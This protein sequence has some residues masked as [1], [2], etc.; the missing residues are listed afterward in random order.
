[1]PELRMDDRTLERTLGD[2]G[3][4]LAYAPPT[5]LRRAV[6]ARIATA[7]APAAR[8]WD[9]IASPRL[10]L[11]PAAIALAV[12][13]LA[14]A[15]ASPGVR[16]AAGEIL[17]IGGIDIFR[18][19]ATA[20]PSRPAGTV[21]PTTRPTV[22]PAPTFGM[23]VTLEQARAQAGYPI[24][25]PADPL[26][27]APDEVYLRV[28]GTNTQVTLLYRV[29]AGIPVSPQ[30]GVS[31]LIVYLPGMLETGFIG[32]GIGP[33]SRVDLLTVNGGPGAWISGAPHQIF[34]RSGSNVETEELRLAGNTLVWQEGPMTIR[35]E[36]AVDQA[37][38]LRIAG[39]MR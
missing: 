20:S 6:L 30:A 35:I 32:K 22:S 39:T 29:R 33:D 37:T 19:P 3:A 36:A 11:R 9:H 34:Y 28:R 4:R 26:L 17:R 2:I 24:M 16:T 8:W 18:V 15:L 1:M 23:P 10:G 21:G 31:A 5:D 27:G 14:V 25:L 13:L 7:P 38:A 12:L